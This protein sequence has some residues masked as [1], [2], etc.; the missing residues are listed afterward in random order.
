VA[1]HKA[2]SRGWND[3]G[4]YWNRGCLF[5]KEDSCWCHLRWNLS[6]H[7]LH[8]LHF[9]CSAAPGMVGSSPWLSITTIIIRN[10]NQSKTQ[11]T[12]TPLW[13]SST[14]S[15][16]NQAAPLL[17][18]KKKGSD[19]TCAAHACSISWTFLSTHRH[20]DICGFCSHS[21]LVHAGM[22][23]VLQAIYVAVWWNIYLEC[24]ICILITP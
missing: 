18:S 14:L 10:Q 5:S 8:S 19:F 24:L 17:G 23:A 20:T 1:W 2:T 11:I 7:N 15:H 9:T 13:S 3:S 12:S 6:S 4:F 21:S 16:A 22:C